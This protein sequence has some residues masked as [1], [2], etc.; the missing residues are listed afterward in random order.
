PHSD[1]WSGTPR[2]P[3]RAQ[4]DRVETGQRLHAVV[5]H[6]RARP[7]IPLAAV[8][9]L[10]P[11]QREA[12]PARRRVEH[13][14][15]LGGDVHADAVSGNGGDVV[16]SCGGPGAPLRPRVHRIT[17]M[18]L[19]S[20]NSSMPTVPP[21]RPRPDCF[22]PPNGAAGLDTMPWFKPTMPVSSRSLTRRA[23]LTSLV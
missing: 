6:H 7:G 23:R 19:V 13:L 18:Y 10:R 22:T 15:R 16:A 2:E 14:D 5:R 3:D 17:A 21:S 20:R 8:V 9:E 11:P 12:V 4:Q 1:T